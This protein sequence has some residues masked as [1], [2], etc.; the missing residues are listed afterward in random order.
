M[1]A[2]TGQ[3]EGD[4]LA[5]ALPEGRMVGTP[6]HDQARCYLLDRMDAIGLRPFTGDSF[7]LPYQ[8][9]GQEF[10][11]LVG[12]AP[13]AD[14]NKAP[15]LIGAHYDSVIPAPCADD[16]AAALAIALG[17]AEQPITTPAARTVVI[18]VSDAAE[19]PHY[20]GPSMGSTRFY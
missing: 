13:G 16:N 18:A 15:V 8:V 19:P 1:M 2:S 12:I 9:D 6:G 4:V 7:E 5:L 14:P 17:A 10:C 20:P 3:L 11:N